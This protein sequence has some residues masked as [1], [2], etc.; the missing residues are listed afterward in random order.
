MQSI[1]PR[2]PILVLFLSLSL[3]AVPAWGTEEPAEVDVFAAALRAGASIAK[4]KARAFTFES[5]ALAWARTDF[6]EE[7]LDALRAAKDVVGAEQALE[8]ALI[9]AETVADETA[10]R[11]LTFARGRI[12][13]EP[14]P[15]QK[16]LH[17][18]SLA[19]AY[20]QLEQDQDRDDTAAR[21]TAALPTTC[22]PLDTVLGRTA[23]AR[24]FLDVGMEAWAGRLLPGA[25]RVAL[26]LPGDPVGLDGPWSPGDTPEAALTDAILGHLRFYKDDAPGFAPPPPLQGCPAPAWPAGRVAPEKPVALAAV[27]TVLRRLGDAENATLARE[28]ASTLVRGIRDAGDRDRAADAAA[29]LLIDEAPAEDAVSFLSAIARTAPNPARKAFAR[30]VFSGRLRSR[31]PTGTFLQAVMSLAA[32]LG[33]PEGVED[34]FR[35]A[36]ARALVNLGDPERAHDVAITIEAKDL[37]QPILLEVLSALAEVDSGRAIVSVGGLPAGWKAAILFRI[38]VALRRHADLDEEA[39]EAFRMAREA[40][41]KSPKPNPGHVEALLASVDAAKALGEPRDPGVL[42]AAR[43]LAATINAKGVGNELLERIG[44]RYLRLGETRRVGGI[45]RRMTGKKRDRLLWSVAMH[46]LDAGH[47]AASLE[48]ICDIRSPGRR[49]RAVAEVALRLGKAGGTLDAAGADILRKMAP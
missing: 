10:Q 16:A 15:L 42:E 47:S 35:A 11:L 13:Q 8:T 34:Q 6:C 17:L 25:A 40:M 4:A 33:P 49:V 41:P 5:V 21:A 38:G 27:A 1:P 43:K 18:A 2:I 32:S 48:T 26:D 39:D 24:R 46:Q 29:T 31:S 20:E 44:H 14:D 28:V 3:P 7:A 23:L 37:R 12:N 22:D 36:L 45:A 19:G 30:M 9:C